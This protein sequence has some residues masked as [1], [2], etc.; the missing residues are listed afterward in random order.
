MIQWTGVKNELPEEQTFVRVNRFVNGLAVRVP[1]T[2]RLKGGIWYGI[3]WV[4]PA[5]RINGV[6]HWQFL[7]LSESSRIA[8]NDSN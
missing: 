7:P 2:G 5:Q 8:D 3:D 1:I 6:T 4:P